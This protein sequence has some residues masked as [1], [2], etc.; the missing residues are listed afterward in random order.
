MVVAINQKQESVIIKNHIT[1]SVY[2]NGNQSK[3]S[4][5][6]DLNAHAIFTVDSKSHPA[7]DRYLVL[8]DPMR[9]GRAICLT[10]PSNQN[11]VFNC[12]VMS[13]NHALLW[14]DKGSFFLK[15]I[16]LTRFLI[17][18]SMRMF[19]LQ[20]LES[21]NGTFVNN[22]K[23]VSLVPH[24]IQSGDI[25]QFGINVTDNSNMHDCIV[26]TFKLFPPE[27]QVDF[28]NV[29]M[30]NAQISMDQL[31]SLNLCIQEA[32]Q[33]EFELENKMAKVHEFLEK[34][35]A[36]TD[37]YWNNFIKEDKLYST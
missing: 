12:K 10:M 7:A 33:R 32:L 9:I 19:I 25:I 37:M 23:L 16:E 3:M 29:G 13:R 31:H 35:E 24:V 6:A 20:D 2:L 27:Y 4:E 26:G 15:V 22:V 18:F 36:M 17:K 14:Y 34:A 1:S 21:S 30:K 8:D 28:T 11:L 5:S